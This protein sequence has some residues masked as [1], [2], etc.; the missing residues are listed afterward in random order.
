M[1]NMFCSLLF[2]AVASSG[3]WSQQPNTAAESAPVI[4]EILVSGERPGPALWSA[5]RDG[6]K[7][8]ILGMYA[9]LPAAMSWRSRE[10]E[11]RIAESQVVVRWVQ[12]ETDVEMGF[13]AKLGAISAVMSLGDN[14]KGIKLKDRVAPEAYALWA[15]LKQKYIS[16]GVKS[17]EDLRPA[18]AA[19]ELRTQAMNQIGLSSPKP[20]SIVWPE[21]EHLAKKHRVKIMEPEVRMSI[22][23]EQPREV[24]GRFRNTELGDAECFAK[25][26]ARLE[27]DL[28]VMKARANAWS[29]GDLDLLR[30]IPPPDPSLDCE[31]LMRTAILNGTLLKQLGTP[32]TADKAERARLEFDRGLKAVNQVWMDTALFRV[33]AGADWR[34]VRYEWT[35]AVVTRARVHGG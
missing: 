7:L 30:T 10:V 9:P 34:S 11:T 23:V 1:R 4:E 14:P 20:E 2:L 32:E 3:A 33:C 19:S 6:K 8:W 31:Q 35:V 29:V 22:E 17:V 5:T 16:R 13:F 27:D 26:V 12:L 24:I 18:F 15:R 21:V 25:S 28:V